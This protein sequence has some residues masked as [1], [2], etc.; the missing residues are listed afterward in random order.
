MALYH[1]GVIIIQS[2]LNILY[3]YLHHINKS[4]LEIC[5]RFKLFE[6]WES[7]SVLKL[8]FSLAEEVAGEA[9]ELVNGYVMRGRPV[10]VQYGRTRD[11]QTT[12]SGSS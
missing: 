4:I 11:D 3:T 9:M 6:W 2:G 12:G 7:V 1:F 10:V 8:F 5:G